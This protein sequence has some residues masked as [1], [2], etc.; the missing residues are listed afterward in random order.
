MT[1]EEYRT[2]YNKAPFDLDEFAEAALTLDAGVSTSTR[3]DEEVL[4]TAANMYL[5]AKQNFQAL[6]IAF[7]VHVG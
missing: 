5:K 1:L 3:T 4:Q 2:K 6:L 7:R